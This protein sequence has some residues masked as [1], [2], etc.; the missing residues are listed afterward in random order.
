MQEKVSNQKSMGPGE[1]ADHHEMEHGPSVE[2]Y[3]PLVGAEMVERSTFEI[4][5]W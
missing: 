3:E 4:T 5:I 2:D 1:A